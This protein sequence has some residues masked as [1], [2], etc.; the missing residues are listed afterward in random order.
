MTEDKPKRFPIPHPGVLLVV[1]LVVAVIVVFLIGWVPY[2][3]EQV[4]IRETQR[5]E[6][7]ARDARERA[8][9]EARE[10][11]AKPTTHP[12]TACLH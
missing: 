6:K 8:A 1:A 7:A 5:V 4:A 10:A 11:A 12:T 9:R 2:Q 3:R